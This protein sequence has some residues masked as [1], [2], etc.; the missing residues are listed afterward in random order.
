MPKTLKS[1]CILYHSCVETFVKG[2][3]R[4]LW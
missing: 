2:A 4:N 1:V 3:N